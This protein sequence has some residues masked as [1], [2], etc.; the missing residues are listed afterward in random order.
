[1]ING[2]VVIADGT[3]RVNKEEYLKHKRELSDA[4]ILLSI[5]GTIG[6]LAL[7]NNEQI[8]LGKSACYINISNEVNKLFIFYCLQTSI[9]SDFFISELTGT[10]IKN[11]SLTT[12][13][14]CEISI[15]IIAEQQKISAF[16]SSIDNK[17]YLTNTQLEK[18]EL[19]KKGLL[20]KM[21]I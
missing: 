13:K 10:T 4:T 12:I 14:N 15:P 8:I 11:L 20:Q 21:F 1:L 9:I 19:L 6:S 7:Y 3:K 17:I 2:K 5:N 16:L 18:T